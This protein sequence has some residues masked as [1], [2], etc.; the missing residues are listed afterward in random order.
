MLNRFLNA[1]TTVALLLLVTA[2]FFWSTP[3][4]TFNRSRL[5]GFELRPQNQLR[6]DILGV[7]FPLISI[8]IITFNGQS[9]L[10]LQK[11]WT[12]FE[13]NFAN[14]MR[15]NLGGEFLNFAYLFLFELRALFCHNLWRPL[16]DGH[17]FYHAHS[18]HQDGAIANL[19]GITEISKI[20]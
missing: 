16:P 6:F 10:S 19:G 17:H 3:C 7:K 14:W 20:L 2:R 12:I 4:K 1:S 18:I 13:I 8:L 11:N 5:C 15:R 9:F